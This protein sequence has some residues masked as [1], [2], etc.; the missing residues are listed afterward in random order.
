M[1]TK[2]LFD[3]LKPQNKDILDKNMNEYP[4]IIT[5]IIKQLQEKEFITEITYGC[6]IDMKFFFLEDTAFDYFNE[7]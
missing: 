1:K 5:Y 6:Y 4:T 2:T 7:I 3:R